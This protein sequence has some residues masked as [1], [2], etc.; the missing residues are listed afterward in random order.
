MAKPE[1][2]KKRTCQSQSCGGVFYD[3]TKDPATCPQCGTKDTLKP[4][5][6]PRRT[7][8]APK[9]AVVKASAD[10]GANDN[11]ITEDTEVDDDDDLANDEDLDEGDDLIVDASDLDG[12]DVSEVK[13]HIEP[14]GNKE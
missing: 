5:L 8:A 10:E 13:E 9:P 6:K 7:P 1:W 11:G 12:D 3:M 4:K 2:G 14:E